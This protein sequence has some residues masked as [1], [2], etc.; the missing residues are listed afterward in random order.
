M[1]F[2]AAILRGATHSTVVVLTLSLDAVVSHFEVAVGL[3]DLVMLSLHESSL[4]VDVLELV[5]QNLN[6]VLSS[7]KVVLQVSAL[8]LLDGF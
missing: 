5:L 4:G 2:V 7:S 6:I 3:L 1:R 8:T